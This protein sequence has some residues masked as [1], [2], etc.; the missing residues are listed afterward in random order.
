MIWKY[1]TI[2]YIIIFICIGTV[3][4]SEDAVS[5][6][7]EPN[8]KFDSLS[9]E[10]GL[11][12][13]V[14]YTIAQDKRGL[15]WFG[16]NDKLNMY[17]GYDFTVYAH[18]PE[19]P[20]SISSNSASNIY[21]D[22][23]DNVWIGTW[24]G[25]L[26]KFDYSKQRF[27]TY[28][29][30]TNDPTSISDNRVQTVFEGNSGI[31][32]VGTYE[33]GLN[34]FDK[35]SGT[36]TR[37][38][39]DPSNPNSISHN[40]IWGICDD[41][42]G[43]LIIA[44]SD[45]LSYFDVENE[46][47]ERFYHQPDNETSIA[48]SSVRT[49]QRGKNGRI[50]IGT[51][52]GISLF[53]AEDGSF[54][55]YIPDNEKFH[56]PPD[57]DTNI[58]S[59][60]LEDDS[61]RLWVGT[62]HGLFKFN[63]EEKEFVHH[64]QANPVD[65]T[66]LGHNNV[67]DIYQDRS[68][69]IW[70]GTRGGGINKFNPNT[71]FS[72]MYD[73]GSGSREVKDITN[74]TTG[75]IWISKK[76][77]VYR[78]SLQSGKTQ[79]MLDE[80]AFAFYVDS[81]GFVWLGC[82]DGT[83]R[84]YDPHTGDFEKYRILPREN[85]SRNNIISFCEDENRDLWIGT[86]GRGVSRFD[87]ETQ[88]VKEHYE[89]KPD[90]K[91]GIS[92]N[93]VYDIYR[94]S[95]GRLWLGTNYGLNLYDRVKKDF[96]T[97]TDSYVYSIF[98][99]S[100]TG[101]WFGS[102]VGLYNLPLGPL[103]NGKNNDALR[104]FNMDDGLSNNMVFGILG[105]DDGNIWFSTSFGISM[106]DIDNLL[107]RNYSEKYGLQDNKFTP[108]CYTKT[109]SGELYFGGVNGITSFYPDE[110]KENET[111]PPIYITDFTINGEGLSLHQPINSIDEIDLSHNDV[112]FSIE[113][114]VLDYVDTAEN[115]YAYKL[116]GL[117]RDWNYV[118]NR[119]FASYTNLRPGQYTFKV[120]GANSDG[121]WNNK[122]K[123]ISINVI[124]AF[125]QTIW[126]KVLVIVIM[127]ITVI[128]FFQ[129]N[130]MRVRKRNIELEEAVNE[131]TASLI[132]AKQRLEEEVVQRKKAEEAIKE[133]AYYDHLTDLPNRRLFMEL[134]KKELNYA[135]RYSNLF[136]LVF[137]D[138][139]K[140]KSINDTYGHEAGDVVLV[141]VSKRINNTIRKS[142]ISCRLGGDEFI[143]LLKDIAEISSVIKITNKLIH[144]IIQ[145]IKIEDG[146]WVEVGVSIGISLF[147][148]D[149][150]NFEGLITKADAAMYAAK[151]TSKPNYIL[152]SEMSHG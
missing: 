60:I 105:D 130:T 115:T 91:R 152:Y 96:I 23:S 14:V 67:R 76:K 110:I 68:G 24:G 92:G 5:F 80:Q 52:R 35:N 82:L 36:F 17:N 57:V 122:G 30:D 109:E 15:M 121:I 124:P 18:D 74:D 118:G 128:A 10:D 135:D 51:A 95:Q 101:I 145:S 119:R 73:T 56:L 151:K 32:W 104:L 123:S 125:W 49:V 9:M 133:I 81:F 48:S 19:D 61:G 1:S 120:K 55:N 141:E 146:V 26:I 13:D 103:V 59:T 85:N 148:N 66:S 137:I 107:F 6:I 97:Y 45:G 2:L 54:R 111:P 77:S 7:K 136:A 108:T 44:T 117:D 27:T 37:Y 83:I 62:A 41:K 3:A 84:K 132:K 33:G 149:D 38:Q 94:D 21:I 138:L 87:P 129:Y 42:K 78:Y 22:S 86:D 43:N 113:F 20:A 53:D 114:A 11:S 34:K 12:N 4:Y 88:Q 8:I 72:Y 144:K 69:V 150:E 89:K 31:L 143:L 139:D 116:E 102:R 65:S 100:K 93:E 70:I 16:T 112:L 142:D 29:Y 131:R 47:F 79:K 126:F 39:H 75:S 140:F 25:G 64:Y 98:E 127:I 99:D 63:I 147:P 71:V 134:G 50:W 46:V 58:T 106:L 40:R 28:K 90:S